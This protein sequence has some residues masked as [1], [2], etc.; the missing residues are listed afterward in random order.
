MKMGRAD[1]STCWVSASCDLIRVGGEPCYLGIIQDITE[2]KQ[3]EEAQQNL[4]HASRLALIGE[5]TASIAHEINQPLG[6]ILSNAEAAEMMLSQAEPPLDQVRAILSDIRKDDLRASEVIKGVRA[7]VSKRSGESQPLDLRVIVTDVLALLRPDAERRGVKLVSTIVAPTPRLHGNR[8]QLEQVLLNLFLN[9][10]EA[11]AGTPPEKRRI[12]VQATNDHSRHI[13]ISVKDAGHGIP[14]DEIPRIFDSFFTTKEHGMG[15]GL[16]MVRS[17]IELHGGHIS[18][19]NN[20]DGGATFRF[21]LPL[22]KVPE[23][24]P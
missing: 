21:Q 5:L 15:L 20:P 3:A 24:E 23:T 14:P 18:A 22:D 10:M 6:A 1:G 2:R 9:G 13:E 16:A 4:A 7:L 11:M 19:E 17:I 8:V 12:E